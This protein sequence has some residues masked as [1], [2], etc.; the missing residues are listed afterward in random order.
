MK[1]KLAGLLA[2]ATMS[3]AALAADTSSV[4]RKIQTDPNPR[5]EV[6]ETCPV[7]QVVSGVEI[8]SNMTSGPPMKAHCRPI[9]AV[10]LVTGKAQDWCSANPPVGVSCSCDAQGEQLQWVKDGSC[11]VCKGTKNRC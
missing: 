3:G 9:P 5:T 7:G 1:Q 10:D 8:L 11:W 2:L 6:Q 4:G